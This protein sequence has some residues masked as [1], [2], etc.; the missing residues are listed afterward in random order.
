MLCDRWSKWS[1]KIIQTASR[2]SPI[3]TKKR[4]LTFL[5]GIEHLE[6]RCTPTQVVL[7]DAADNT[8]YQALNQSSQLSNA[9]GQHFF[10]GET[11]QGAGSNLRRGVLRFDLSSVPAGS[12]ITSVTLTLHMSL[13]TSGAE[14]FDL[15]LLQQNWGEGTSLAGTGGNGEGN[16]AAAT[17]NDVTWL[18]TFYDSTNPQFWTTA[19]GTFSSTTSATTSVNGGGFYSW[20]GSGL[21]SDVQQW[22][23]QSSTN[24][25]WIMIGNETSNGT[26]KQFDT[27]EN[28]TS[29]NQ[30][31][32][33]VN[34]TPGITSVVINQD[35]SALYNA[36]GQPFAGAQRS[37]VNDIAYTFSQPVNILDPGTDPSVFTVAVASG[38]S[39]TVPT[40][41]WAAVP[42]SGDTQ[43]AVAF[44][45][46]GVTGGSIANG[47]YTITVADPN[48]ITAES[49][50]TALSFAS[51]GIDS[52]TQ[53]F[54]RL[55]GDINGD[56]FVNAA[57]NAKLKQALST[58]NAAFD[59]SQDGFVNAADNA[60][61]KDDLTVNFNGFTPTI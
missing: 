27:R 37:M 2:C 36:A 13:S 44:S 56:G 35:I 59:Y 12:T 26:A 6:E 46:A 11:N 38:W 10:A 58:Y 3:S 4:S 41:N 24:F 33:T 5:P 8:L 57:D 1:R 18:D 61:F 54:F 23:N 19:G 9:L 17:T 53:S 28:A 29:A 34:Y 52:A 39:G 47:A 22:V 40:L 30:P 55:F 7:G 42:G 31:T 16:G 45:G 32:L 50:G 60:Q 21:T 49:D 48:S 20:T 15:H 51:S 14:N 25:G 43:W